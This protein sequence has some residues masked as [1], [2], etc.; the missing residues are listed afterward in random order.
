[1]LEHLKDYQD[2]LKFI[3]SECTKNSSKAEELAYELFISHDLRSILKDLPLKVID[4]AFP[5]KYLAFPALKDKEDPLLYLKK[6]LLY[7][8]SLY[9]IL[10]KADK[11]Y[12]RSKWARYLLTY[13]G[14]A[15]WAF[16]DPHWLGGFT[17]KKFLLTKNAVQLIRMSCPTIGKNS[18]PQITLEFQAFLSYLSQRNLKHTYINLQDD[19]IPCYKERIGS[20]DY[21]KDVGFNEES[22]RVFK[23]RELELIWKHFNFISLS[24]DSSF[25][26]QKGAYETKDRFIDFYQDF[27]KQIKLPASVPSSFLEENLI[28]I[29]KAFF[30]NKPF[31]S[32][33]ERL[34]FIEITYCVIIA[35]AIKGS[36]SA[37]ITC[38]DGI[39]RA[40]ST[41]GLIFVFG[42]I[43]KIL[44]QN[45]KEDLQSYFDH[46]ESMIFSDAL[47]VKHRAIIK[48][49]FDRFIETS[50]FIVSL[51]EKL[52][53]F[54]HIFDN[55]DLDLA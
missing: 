52:K 27:T 17:S 54:S 47:M 48:R 50:L 20:F 13:K 19:R 45:S 24:K 33:K 9:P 1:M 2:H 12:G 39:D 16:F 8:Q 31:L 10:K 32:Q 26:H 41:H 46:M 43:K 21:L 49:R 25:Y 37:N 51:G 15:N 14:G 23:I 28:S 38:K 34:Y 3:R 44:D 18:A 53:T 55:F 40:G 36:Y 7:L 5:D 42:M 30:D 4:R 22:F 35:A 11:Y 29:H 6:R